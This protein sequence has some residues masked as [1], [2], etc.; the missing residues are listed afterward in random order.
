MNRSK[1]P[2]IVRL[3][4]SCFF[5]HHARAGRLDAEDAER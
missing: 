2:R 3:K 5:I 4:A 1:T